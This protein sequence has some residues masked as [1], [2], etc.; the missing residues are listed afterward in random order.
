VSDH[1]PFGD[2]AR[3][4][5]PRQVAVIDAAVAAAD[6][7]ASATLLGALAALTDHEPLARAVRGLARAGALAHPEVAAALR[8]ALEVAPDTG[9]QRVLRGL[10]RAALAPDALRP[11]VDAVASCLVDLPLARLDGL[12]LMDRWLKNADRPRRDALRDAAVAACVA[13]L[14]AGAPEALDDPTLVRVPGARYADLTAHAARVGQAAAWAARRRRFTADVLALLHGAPRSL[15]Q[16]NAEELLSRRVYTDPGHFLVELLQNAEDAGA[17]AFRVTIDGAGVTAWHDGAPFDAR[18]VVGV[19]SIGQTTKSRDQIGFFGVGFK[20]VYEVCERPQVY[21]DHFRFEIADVSI[22]RPLPER[23]ASDHP[24]GGTL[25][26]LPYRAPD[27]P[28]RTPEALTGRALAVPPETLLTLRNLQ[29]FDVAGPSGARRVTRDD[30]ARHVV[31][32]QVDSGPD[33][34]TETRRYAVADDRFTYAGPLR[35]LSRARTTRALV[36]VALDADGVPTPLAPDAPTI[37]SHLPTGE[38]SG[39]RFVVHGHFD[40]PVDR[41]RLDLSSPWN[42]WA[43]GRAGELLATLAAELCADEAASPE[44]TSGLLDVLPLPR[45]LRDPAYED[46]ADTARAGLAAL[47][48]LPGAAGQRLTP[49]SARLVAP[50]AL[51]AALADAPLDDAGRRATAPLTGRRA[52]V[53]E[54]LGAEPFGPADLAALLTTTLSGLDDGAPYPAPWLLPGIGALLDALGGALDDPEGVD[55]AALAELPLLPDDAGRAWRPAALR[56]VGP[57]LRA[58]YGGRGRPFLRATLDAAPTVAQATLFRCLGV[59]HHDDAAFVADLDTPAIAEA[60]LAASGPVAV[61]THLATLGRGLTRDLARK[62]LFP[63]LSGALHPVAPDAAERA[64]LPPTEPLRAVV[65]DLPA[66]RCVPVVAPTLADPLTDYLRDLGAEPLDLTALLDQ[67]ARG[68]V[69]LGDDDLAALHGALSRLAPSLTRREAAALSDAAIFADRAG[70]LRPLV[71]PERALLP[72]DAAVEALAPDAPWLAP[73]LR[74]LPH[75]TRLVTRPTGAA[76]VVAGLW[77]VDDEAPLVPLA[78]LAGADGAP[79]RERLYTYLAEHRHGLAGEDRTH[80]AETALWADLDGALHP[81]DEVRADAEDPD[82][83]SLFEALDRSPV[84]APG[85]AALVAALDLDAALPAR[86]L[87]RL[88]TLLAVQEDAP[89]LEGAAGELREALVRQLDRAAAQLD[90][91]ALAPLWHAPIFRGDDGL[92][93]VPGRWDAPPADAVYRASGGLRAALA[94][95]ARPLLCAEDEAAFG[96]ALDALGVAPADALSFVA[97]LESDGVLASPAACERARAALIEVAGTLRAAPEAASLAERLDALAL[98]PT[99]DGALRRG[100]EVVRLA[101]LARLVGQPWADDLARAAP[102]LLNEDAA[103]AATALAGLVTFQAPVALIEE[104]VTALARPGAPLEEQAPLLSDP[105]RLAVLLRAVRE[106]A[107]EDAA[108]ALPLWVNADGALASGPLLTLEPDA[109]P[110][111]RGLPLRALVAEPEWAALANEEDPPLVGALP[112]ARLVGELA[113][114][115]RE[116]PPEGAPAPLVDP[117]GRASFYRWLLRH[118][119]TI[120]ADPQAVGTLGNAPLLPT[121]AGGWRAPR[122]LLLADGAAGLDLPDDVGLGAWRL[123]DEV[124]APLERWLA[125]TVQLERGR[126]RQL[127]TV[128]VDAHRQAEADADAARSA[129]LL[130]AMAGCWPPPAEGDDDE[131]NAFEWAVKNHKLR[132]LR[133]A[134]AGGTWEQIRRL[135]CPTGPERALLDVFLTAAVPLAAPA[136]EDPTV[137]G[138]LARVGAA[139]ALPATQLAALLAGDEGLAPGLEASLAL[140]RYVATVAAEAPTALTGLDLDRVAWVPDRTGARRRPS[141]LYWPEPEVTAL[142]GERPTLYPHP[143]LFLTLPEALVAALPFRGTGDALLADV[144]RTIT[145]SGQRGAPATA[146]AWLDRGLASGALGSERTGRPWAEDTAARRPEAIEDGDARSAIRAAFA[147]PRLRDDDGELR[148]ADQLVVTPAPELVGDFLTGWQDGAELPALAEALGIPER[149]GAAEVARYLDHVG[150]RLAALGADTLLAAEPE[151]RQRL[152]RGLTVLARRGGRRGRPLPLMVT[153]DD[154]R[155]TLAMS[156]HPAVALPRPEG[157]AVAAQAAGLPLLLVTPPWQAEEAALRW[158][159]GCGVPDLWALFT[160]DAAPARLAGDVTAAFAEAVTELTAALTRALAQAAVAQAVGADAIG[161]RV[162]ERLEASGTLVGRALSFAVP[163]R[164]DASRARLVVTPAALSDRPAVAEA[165]ARAVDAMADAPDAWAAALVLAMEGADVSAPAGRA[166]REDEERPAEAPREPKPPERS[167]PSKAEE[168]AEATSP[169]QSWWSRA[170]AWLRG[171]SD[172]DQPSARDEP[173][174]RPAPRDARD[175]A[176]SRQGDAVPVP[177]VDHSR[178]FEARDAVGSQLDS[179]GTFSI[180]RAV[181]P[182]FG[183]SFR[184]RALPFP[185]RYAPQGIVGRFERGSQRWLPVTDRDARRVLADTL[186]PVGPGDFVVTL[187]GRLPRGDNYFPTPLY[188]RLLAAEGDDA[189]VRVV[190]GRG[191]RTFVVASAPTAV[192]CRVVLDVAPRFAGLPEPFAPDSA[193]RGF[194]APTVPD[195]ELPD[196]ALEA[197]ERLRVADLPAL[198][199]ALAVR[200]FIQRRYRY[201]P[202]YLEDA[203]V[204]RWLRR[205]TRGRPN[206]HIAALHAGAGGRYLGRGVCYELG[207]LA[208]E[209]LRRAGIPAAISSGWVWEGGQLTDADHLWAMALLPTDVGLRWLPIDPATRDGQA[210]RVPQRPPGDFG[211]PEAPENEAPPTSSWDEPAAERGDWEA[212][213]PPPPRERERRS[214]RPEPSPQ[215]SVGGQRQTRKPPRKRPP[216]PPVG[217]LLRVVQ[218]LAEVSGERLDGPTLYRRCRDLLAD[219]RRAA[220]LLDAMGLADDDS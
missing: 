216:K 83:R 61:H 23:P 145:A 26:V 116:A 77:G 194:L 68:A 46:L 7:T 165:I 56:R 76:D 219:P 147:A 34:P 127:M 10:D 152:P 189:R 19:L 177:E 126:R 154:G 58:L 94:A 176:P 39:L 208:C 88:I 129:A 93:R 137:V 122:E 89:W 166:E 212:P 98:W 15:S 144:L 135:L 86:D 218:H 108:A 104:R 82:L 214:P 206:V 119:E 16:A 74:E 175:D 35:E 128:L 111:T 45:E 40:V 202:S 123:A 55:A 75:V 204:A 191:G 36:A 65:L 149:V 48:L 170:R 136:Y 84:I 162:V 60:V 179:G 21:S 107:D 109:L 120:A 178:W 102:T 32:L 41:E 199:K 140:S 182:D 18:D 24:D 67:L 171:D 103:P 192:S 130:R 156:D 124:P 64:W 118:A 112:V 200:A 131:A 117:E 33:T 188:G 17:S 167:E 4:P 44:A 101:D 25:L 180:E 197:V 63:T 85:A 9:V 207:A 187:R 12:C 133:V 37:F 205:V 121:D 5:F 164:Y 70:A 150:E 91:A 50:A 71:G 87:P 181:A 30:A 213:E 20:S 153:G 163:A 105:E 59:A 195:E 193:L 201:D 8:A 203:A 141:E 184:P 183:F 215:R 38:R 158:L 138:F 57:T 157:L 132:Q 99:A 210:L 22:P 92:A 2:L 160:P 169:S 27:D 78:S 29:R 73:Q 97:A 139:R 28:E 3:L 11:V 52:E 190:A 95:G 47:P 90:A 100:P 142:V 49:P 6:P 161:V 54:D 1:P 115:A 114:A 79:L 209:L 173:E 113:A 110:L 185:H 125:A 43:L 14:D 196:E 146:L 168:P 143:E 148:A 31:A 62:P 53:A 172:D 159:G 220:A 80:L 66:D 96:A 151:L 81:L 186:A 155:P 72:E 134:T 198:D 174:T 211:R 42:R 106:G 69:V 51:A 217:E 13:A